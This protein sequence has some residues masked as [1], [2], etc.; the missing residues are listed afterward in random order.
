MEG[1]LRFIF[2]LIVI[3]YSFK[4]VGRW[5][6]PYL[7]KRYMNRFQKKFFEQN[8]NLDPNFKTKEEGEVKIKY[9]NKTKTESDSIGDYV[10]YEEVKE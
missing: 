10:D 1:A 2:I 5:V 7:I 8:P 3:Y 4:V 6:L 9:P